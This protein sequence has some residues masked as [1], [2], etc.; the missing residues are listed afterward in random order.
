GLDALPDVRDEIS[1]DG[2]DAIARLV[3]DLERYMQLAA[4]LP[5]GELLYRFLEDTGWLARMSKAATVREE[6]EVQNVAKFFRRLQ[7]ATAVLRSDRAREFVSHLDALIEAGEDPAVAEAEL[8]VPAVHVLTVHKAKGLE[9]PLVFVVGLVQ[10]R[11]PWPQRGDGLEL[12]EG[13]VAGR[14]AGAEFHLQ[15]ERRLL[16]VAMTRPTRA[17]YLTSA[18]H[19]GGRPRPQATPVRPD[20]P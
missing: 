4:E 2:L 11:F 6:A 15:E 5:A 18:P 19:H 7:E 20:A 17:P 13:L 9:F 1:P 12:P 3:K 10:G 14:R 8:D 16:Y